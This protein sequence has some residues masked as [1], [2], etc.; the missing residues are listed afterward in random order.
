MAC[1]RSAVRPRYPPLRKGLKLLWFKVFFVYESVSDFGG[2]LLEAPKSEHPNPL[3][4]GDF[5]SR[6]FLTTCLS[7]YAI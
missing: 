6:R 5:G 2:S 4:I 7:R 3:L 1:K